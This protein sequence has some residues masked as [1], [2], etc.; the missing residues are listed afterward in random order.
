MFAIFSVALGGSRRVC[1]ERVQH[2]P[3]FLRIL[4]APR[5]DPCLGK[6]ALP[7]QGGPLGAAGRSC[8]DG[9][10]CRA[11]QAVR[12]G[13]IDSL[14]HIGV[15]FL[16]SVVD[17]VPL[18]FEPL[19]SLVDLLLTKIKWMSRMSIRPHRGVRIMWYTGKSTIVRESLARVPES[20][21]NIS[22]KVPRRSLA[23]VGG[24]PR[25]VSTNLTA[26]GNKAASANKNVGDK[27]SSHFLICRRQKQRN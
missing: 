16:P 9:L 7:C 23:C 17:S 10:G 18:H 15:H 8:R 25:A 13:Q 20:A 3:R 6:D 22:T 2:S 26:R 4:Y 19:A 1:T 12:H 24:Q 5:S 11:S 27:I 21:D 14:L